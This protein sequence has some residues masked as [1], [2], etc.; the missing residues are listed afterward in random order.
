MAQSKSLVLELA[1]GIRDS[2]NPSP[3]NYFDRQLSLL[4][5]LAAKPAAKLRSTAL[6]A[7][8][9]VLR[10]SRT[11][12]MWGRF[13]RGFRRS[14]GEGLCMFGLCEEETAALAAA[15]AAVRSAQSI[16]DRLERKQLQARLEKFLERKQ[17]S[18]RL[19]PAIQSEETAP[20]HNF[21]KPASIKRSRPNSILRLLDPPAPPAPEAILDTFAQVKSFGGLAA[22]YSLDHSQTR[23]ALR[24]AGI[25]IYE[26]VARDW[27][28]GTSIQELSRRHGTGRDTIARWIRK[29]GRNIN[30]RNGNRHYDEAL[31]AK[32]FREASSVNRA[33]KAAGV[34][35]A[36][37]RAVLSRYGLREEGRSKPPCNS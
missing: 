1:L 6:S 37:A 2:K 21:P 29:T 3:R 14:V 27:D 34:S 31:I 9:I 32:T 25:D 35:W 15:R 17:A 36:T 26:E 24:D 10:S 33:A 13:K 28:R 11:L 4:L 7:A 19:I 8:H 16:V 23:R 30:P 20:R 22:T 12:Y 18:I 5:G